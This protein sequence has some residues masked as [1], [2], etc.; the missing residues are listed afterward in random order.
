MKKNLYLWIFIGVAIV[1]GGL[2]W[3]IANNLGGDLNSGQRNI[4]ESGQLK[5]TNNNS[6]AQNNQPTKDLTVE[7]ID[8]EE[9]ADDLSDGLVDD[10]QFDEELNVDS[11]ENEVY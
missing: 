1:L 10:N 7:N 6:P 11:F 3:A 2:I 4:S 5:K 9:D 8:F